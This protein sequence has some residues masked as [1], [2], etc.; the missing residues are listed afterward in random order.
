MMLV[1][2]V[3]EITLL[4]LTAVVFQTETALHVTVFVGRVTMILLV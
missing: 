4:A 1:V 3:V 2:F